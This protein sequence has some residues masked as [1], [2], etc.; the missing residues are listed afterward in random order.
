MRFAAPTASVKCMNVRRAE[1][2]DVADI[3]TLMS[4]L[5]YPASSKL[6]AE[7]L[8]QF[9]QACSDEV[10]VA[11][12]GGKVVGAI[13]CHITS[14]FHQ[15]GSSGRITSLVIDDGCRGSGIGRRLVGE[16][17]KFFLSSGCVKSEVTSGEHR[18]DAHHFYKSCGNQ[19]DE[20]RFIK[21]YT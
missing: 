15:V 12:L 18:L 17:E 1:T 6:L 8:L 4:Q 20:R 5:G 7:K 14:L 16:A 10:F 21:Q 3:A 13:S 9:S 19:E 2:D 11:V